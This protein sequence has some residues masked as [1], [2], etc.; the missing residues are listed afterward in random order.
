MSTFVLGTA[1]RIITP[2]LGTPLYG[3]P[4]HRPASAV[5]DNLNV[6]V[7]AIGNDKPTALLFNFDLCS[8]PAVL[9]EEMHK[10]ISDE[11]GIA[12]DKIMLS[13]THTHSGPCITTIVGWGDSNS[14][15]IDGIFKPMAIE[16]AKEA[17]ANAVP[18]VM[19]VGTTESKVG[20]NRRELRADGKIYLGQNPHGMYDPTMT[21]L[22]FKSPDGA[23]IANI[24]HYGCHGTSA[25]HDDQITRDWCGFMVD[26]ME[27]LTGATTLFINGAEGDVGPR[28]SNGKTTG[29]HLS[30]TREIG[31]VA[32]ID[33]VRAYRTIKEYREVDF[34]AVSDTIRIPYRPFDSLESLKA[35][36]EGYGDPETMSAFNRLKCGTAKQ[37][38]ELLESGAALDTHKEIPQVLFAFNSVVIVPFQYEMFC[39]ITLRLRSY[40]KFQ[41]T[42]G[43]CNTN[44]SYAYLP[45]QDQICRGGYEIEQFLKRNV[46][47]LVDNADDY[48]INENLRIMEKLL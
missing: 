36:I 45:S 2:P 18:V 14:D 28:L 1:R 30:Y 42:L 33:A 9:A 22:S 12:H 37:K 25:G 4:N 44:G 39:E 48:I 13:M 31:S 47:S 46:Y 38:V 35:E 40:S 10:I 6:T 34:R 26:R 16:A 5:H 24:V 7:A 21:V 43:I 11:T 32:A 41:H 23:P 19:G 20:I 29:N 8:I 27:E 3:Y 17:I 15:Y